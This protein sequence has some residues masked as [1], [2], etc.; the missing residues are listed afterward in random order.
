MPTQAEVWVAL[1]LLGYS[2]MFTM[3][4]QERDAWL[5]EYISVPQPGPPWETMI[6]TH[7]GRH[8]RLTRYDF[9]DGS[10]VISDE[11]WYKAER[12]DCVGTPEYAYLLWWI[13][14]HI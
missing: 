6:H 9:P 11:T 1:C 7:Q 5:T 13:P 3:T 8:V 4:Q 10:S 2:A 12:P 14:V